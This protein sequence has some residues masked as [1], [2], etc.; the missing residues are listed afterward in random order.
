[1]EQ[2]V[3]HYTHIW[4]KGRLLKEGVLM[5]QPA[6]WVEAMLVIDDAV[7]THRLKRRE[8]EEEAA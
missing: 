6:R 5:D 1:M 3:W 4:A 7:R 8:E 2:W